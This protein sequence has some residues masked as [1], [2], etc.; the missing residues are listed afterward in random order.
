MYL[1]PYGCI[2]HP[3]IMV[4]ISFVNVMIIPP[5][6]VRNPL[7]LCDGSCDFSDR[8]TCMIPSPRRISP[9]ARIRLKMKFDRLFT[10]D[11]GSPAAKHVPVITVPIITAAT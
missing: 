2:S 1:Q 9:M 7:A 6:R 4:R 3:V 10:T 5:A 11:S 8:P